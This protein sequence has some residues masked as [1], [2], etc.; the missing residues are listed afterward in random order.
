MVLAEQGGPE[1]LWEACQS[2]TAYRGNNY[3]PLLPK[4]FKS[5]RATLFRLLRSLK[6]HSTTQNQ[7]LSEAFELI[8]AKQ[9][10]RAKWLPDTLELGFAS[11]LWQKTI[12]VRKGHKR[13]YRLKH[14]L[15]E[16]CVFSYLAFELRTGDMYVEGT[17]DYADYRE[18]LLSW[19]E[20]QGQ[21]EKY[22]LALDLPADAKSFVEHLKG[23]LNQTATS[24]N[25]GFAENEAVSINPAGL[26]VLKKLKRKEISATYLALRS[27]L[28]QK[29]NASPRS[30]LEVLA[31]CNF[32]CDWSRHFG[33]LSGTEAK[34]ERAIEKYILTVFAYGANL[35]PVQTAA[36]LGGAD[37]AHQLAFLNRTHLTTAKLEAANTELINTYN[38][39]NLPKLWGNPKIAAADGT[40][41]ELPDNSLFSQYH[42]R[43]RHMGGIACHHILD[44]YIALFSHFITCSTYEA[45]YIIDGLLK[46][47]SDIQPDTLTADTHGQSTVVFGLSHLLGIKL[48]PRIRNWKDLIFFRPDKTSPTLNWIAFSGRLSTGLYWRGTGR[49]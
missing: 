34:L 14:R 4:Y 45:V 44:I 35:G 12:R 16:I 49:I 5:H 48:M 8:L 6:I 27:A 30:L 21:V 47:K 28:H 9:N 46:N 15:L 23:R 32:W 36:H 39:F 29:L 7:A 33:P 11:E 38:R 37:S 18:Q 22:C 43:Y 24:V 19:E 41:I 1:A 40:K 13:K 42:F 10:S 17:E 25:E 20:C 31:N 2:I 3:L 26:P